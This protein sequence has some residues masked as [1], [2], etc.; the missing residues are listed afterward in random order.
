M[1]KPCESCVEAVIDDGADE[2]IAEEALDLMGED[3]ADH[4][5]DE[6]ETQGE[7]ECSCPCKRAAKRRLRQAAFRKEHQKL[8]QHLGGPLHSLPQDEYVQ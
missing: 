7:V 5:C 4:L 3:I 1:T 8:S 2:D 6:I